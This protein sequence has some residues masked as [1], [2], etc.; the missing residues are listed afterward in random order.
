MRRNIVCILLCWSNLTQAHLVSTNTPTLG[1]K[2]IYRRRACVMVW[3]VHSQCETAVYHWGSF[4]Y[5]TKLRDICFA[6]Y[7]S[8]SVFVQYA[9][10]V[11]TLI[12]HTELRKPLLAKLNSYVG[13]GAQWISLCFS[14]MFGLHP[15]V[16]SCGISATY[17]IF[18]TRCH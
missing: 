15:I 8:L 18:A 4:T 11:S 7:F 16:P 6:A 10:S 3:Y 5:H 13:I 2:A 1:H 14:S 9:S 12:F 17:F